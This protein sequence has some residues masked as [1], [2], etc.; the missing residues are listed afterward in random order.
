MRRAV[1]SHSAVEPHDRILLVDKETDINLIDR[2]LPRRHHTALSVTFAGGTS[3]L[4][5]VSTRSGAP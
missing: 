3:P 2:L 1:R 4:S 5:V